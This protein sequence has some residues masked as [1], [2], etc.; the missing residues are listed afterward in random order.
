[1]QASRIF[2]NCQNNEMKIYKGLL[3]CIVS[4][5]TVFLYSPAH[6][7]PA[8]DVQF[9]D[10]MAQASDVKK[11]LNLN[12]NQQVLWQQVESKMRAILSVRLRRRE[13]LQSELKKGLDDPK[14]ELR[15]WAK[16]VDAEA[17][18][19]YLE[20]KQL[21]ELW[22]TVNDALN[23]SQRQTILLLL[24]DQL[25]RVA[26][27]GQESRPGNQPHSQGMGRQRSGGMGGA[28]PQ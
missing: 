19:S 1:V 18:L 20:N 6:A 2:L 4:A 12:S 28:I 13:Q 17:N 27:T 15:D 16:K 21:R 3:T 11:S 23:D 24:S 22:L 9:E 25:Q 14:T 10:L 8:M 7:I 5:I 26:D